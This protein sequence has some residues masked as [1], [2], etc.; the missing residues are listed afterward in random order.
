MRAAGTAV[1]APGDERCGQWPLHPSCRAVT[2][3]RFAFHTQAAIEPLLDG[4]GFIVCILIVNQS[5]SVTVYIT[6]V[7]S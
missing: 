7:Q 5:Y 3:R 6:T 4:F 2:N 1:T